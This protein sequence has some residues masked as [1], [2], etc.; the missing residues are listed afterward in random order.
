M[1]VINRKP[2]HREAHQARNLRNAAD[3]RA[4]LVIREISMMPDHEQFF[5]NV[6]LSDSK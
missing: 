2:M 1:V 5:K 3:R 4:P 6:S